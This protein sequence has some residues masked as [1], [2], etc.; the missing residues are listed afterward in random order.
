MHTTR[1]SSIDTSLIHDLYCDPEVLF[2][3]SVAMKFADDDDYMVYQVRE[4]DYSGHLSRLFSVWQS[5]VS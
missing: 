5:A 1:N 2:E 4:W 3:T